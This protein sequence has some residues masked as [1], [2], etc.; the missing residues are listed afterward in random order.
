MGK[1]IGIAV[2][3]IGCFSGALLIPLAITGNLSAAALNHLLGRDVPVESTGERADDLGPLAQEIILERE[4]LE[5]LASELTEERDRL[6]QRERV[7]DERL[8]EIAQIQAEITSTIDTLD[9][10]RQAAIQAIAKTM[11]AMTAQNAATDLES[12]SP[13]E[14]ARI[15]PLIKDRNR[16]RILDAMDANRR[17]LIIQVMQERKY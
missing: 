3:G 13:E 16:G 11:A 5:E 1:I 4:R 7:M 6:D 10:D 15:L 17:S 9:S 2:L 12:M 8:N 14:A